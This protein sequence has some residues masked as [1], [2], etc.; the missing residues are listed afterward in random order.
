MKLM[1][2][3]YTFILNPT[4]GILLIIATNKITGRMSCNRSEIA[5][6]RS[7]MVGLDAHA[8]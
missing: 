3:M 1:K 5:Q 7:A 8:A 4:H 6:L 2:I